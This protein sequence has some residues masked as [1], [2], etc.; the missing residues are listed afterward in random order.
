MLALTAELNLP[1]WLAPILQQLP[2]DFATVESRMELAIQLSRLNVEHQSGGP[3]GAAIFDMHDYSLVSVGVNSVERCH[4]SMA[5]AEVMAITMAQARLKNYDLGADGR[6]LQLLTSAE[7][8]AMCLASIPWSGV[9]EV[10]CAARDSDVREIGFDEGCK[11]GSWIETLS[12]A[13]IQA[14]AD[15]LRAQAIEVLQAY[16]EGGGNIYNP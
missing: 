13:G 16:A 7:P 4:A 14:Q 15:V 9:R 2:T 10:I 8:C 6:R 12:Q 1:D 11:P 3:F 5:H